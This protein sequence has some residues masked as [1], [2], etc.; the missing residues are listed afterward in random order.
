M[1]SC[2][3]MKNAFEVARN[4]YVRKDSPQNAVVKAKRR[5]KILVAISAAMRD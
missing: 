5:T 3:I 1:G 4:I 2:L